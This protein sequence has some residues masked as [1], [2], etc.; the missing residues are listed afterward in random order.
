MIHVK[1]PTHI[2]LKKMCFLFCP[3]VTGEFVNTQKF[4]T[5]VKHRGTAAYQDEARIVSCEHG[6]LLVVNLSYFIILFSETLFCF[7]V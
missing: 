4:E 5:P 6:L 7:S 1:G 3:V 2:C